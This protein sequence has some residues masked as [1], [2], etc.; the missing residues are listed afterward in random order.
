MLVIIGI[1]Q[2]R[3][4]NI[5][6]TWLSNP[7]AAPCLVIPNISSFQTNAAGIVHGI[8]QALSEALAPRD[9][10]QHRM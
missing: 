8:D 9:T 6:A 3:H 7:P 4:H 5:T 1:S 10:K 2:D